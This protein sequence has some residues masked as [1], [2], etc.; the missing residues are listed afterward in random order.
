VPAHVLSQD[1]PLSIGRSIP[2]F[3]NG[4]LGPNSISTGSFSFAQLACMQNRNTYHAT[5][6]MCRKWPH[7]RTACRRC[8]PVVVYRMLCKIEMKATRG[9]SNYW[10]SKMHYHNHRCS[11]WTPRAD[12]NDIQRSALFTTVDRQCRRSKR[13]FRRLPL[14]L[15]WKSLHKVRCAAQSLRQL[16]F[17]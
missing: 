16:R 6:V 10:T 3:N 11:L 8:G 5:R 17:I 2:P 12:D 4:P 9:L 7:L 13:E 1:C 14:S 15:T